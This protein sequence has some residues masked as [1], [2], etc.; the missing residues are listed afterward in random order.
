[1]G[2]NIVLF[3]FIFAQDNISKDIPL[4]PQ[5]KD[6][7][8]QKGDALSI[9][10]S[11]EPQIKLT[12]SLLTSESSQEQIEQ[13]VPNIP[14]QNRSQTD[15]DS[16]AHNST[17]DSSP[18]EPKASNVLQEVNSFQFHLKDSHRRVEI[19]RIESSAFSLSLESPDHKN[20]LSGSVKTPS[21]SV[22]VSLTDLSSI[23]PIISTSSSDQG[24][25]PESHESLG[26]MIPYTAEVVQ[27]SPEFK[28]VISKFEQT[29][30]SFGGDEPESSLALPG[31]DP[32]VAAMTPY[33][34]ELTQ[35]L[36]ASEMPT[37]LTGD[38]MRLD[39]TAVLD[40]DFP[41]YSLNLKSRP[42]PVHTD[43][44]ESDAEFFDC[45]QTFSDTSEPEVG[46]SELLDVPQA[47]Y[48]VEELPSLSS[49]PEYLPKLREYTQLKKDDR[50]LS[51]GSE[52]LP[53]VLEPEDEYTGEE[54]AFPYDYTGDHSFAEELPP[55]ERFQ[56]DDDDDFLGRVSH[57]A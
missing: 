57:V 29:L 9:S 8:L 28:C 3:P 43:S 52:D 12:A 45:Q 53:I 16:E 40:V 19:N 39:A 20:L 6:L 30:P 35:D 48:Q 13:C 56:Y 5:V 41:I 42:R 44:I 32:F 7:G 23:S 34:L 21:T 33:T 38:Q 14:E 17:P 18:E 11:L 46:S 10:K 49:S 54:K 27:L 26:K 31:T 50:P 1:M 4:E 47:I 36:K 22:Q 2:R 37:K 51:W 55:M 25:S 15:F 24:N